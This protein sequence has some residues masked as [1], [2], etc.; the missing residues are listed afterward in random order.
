[1]LNR[2]NFPFQNVTCAPQTIKFTARLGFSHPAYIQVE[3]ALA[4]ADN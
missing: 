4:A 2:M 3:V 1:M